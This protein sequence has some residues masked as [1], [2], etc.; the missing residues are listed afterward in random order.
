[1]DFLLALLGRWAATAATPTLLELPHEPGRALVA[2]T[3][4]V[5]RDVAV[6]REPRPLGFRL[7]RLSV[8]IR[9]LNGCAGRDGDGYRVRRALAH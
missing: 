5:R 4:G 2:L 9:L 6:G 3:F 8:H 7:G 1:M